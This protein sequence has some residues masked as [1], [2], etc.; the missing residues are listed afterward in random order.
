MQISREDTMTER[1][2]IMNDESLAQV[3]GGA[4]EIGDPKY[5]VG[6]TVALKFANE[7]GVIT[8]IYGTVISVEASPACWWYRVRYEVNGK[9]YEHRYPEFGLN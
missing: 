1:K 9:V 5:N 7:E 8:T 4:G 3:S 6:D 2:V